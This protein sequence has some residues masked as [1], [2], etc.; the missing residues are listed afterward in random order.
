MTLQT[1]RNRA[2]TPSGSVG[3]VWPPR[4]DEH[5]NRVKGFS[6]SP[7]GTMREFAR[8]SSAV[9]RV[10]KE[11]PQSTRTTVRAF[12]EDPLLPR[13]ANRDFTIEAVVPVGNALAGHS[14]VYF[15]RNRPQRVPEAGSFNAE[16]ESLAEISRLQPLP[17]Q[18][19]FMRVYRASYTVESSRPWTGADLSTLLALYREAYQRYT[20][21]ITPQTINDLVDNGNTVVVARKEELRSRLQP[22]E[23]STHQIVSALVAEHCELAINGA[24]PIHLFELSDYATFREHRGNGLMTAMQVEAIRRIRSVFG[25]SAIIYAEDRAAWEAVNRSSRRAGM[26]PCGTLKQHCVLVSDRSF[27]EQG[28]MENLNVWYAPYATPERR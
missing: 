27:G 13:L 25:S 23:F 28:N 7:I 17:S 22:Q 5:N 6:T 9:E 4:Y 18:E 12:V 24:D 16:M 2:G 21:D 26:I 20:F 8:F 15:A 3:A 19:V 11:N 10:E 14:L 1:Q